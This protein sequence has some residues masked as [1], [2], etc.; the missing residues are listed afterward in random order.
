MLLIIA[1]I[2]FIII[3]LIFIISKKNPIPILTKDKDQSTTASNSDKAGLENKNKVERSKPLEDL[4]ASSNFPEVVFYFGSQ[5][6]TAEKFCGIL[7][8]EAQKI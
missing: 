1:A 3:G 2:F 6:G 4:V 7:E 8:Q 5:T